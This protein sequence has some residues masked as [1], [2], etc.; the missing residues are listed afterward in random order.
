[1]TDIDGGKTS[2]LFTDLKDLREEISGIR[3]DIRNVTVQ[4]ASPVSQATNTNH[5]GAVGVWAAAWIASVCCAAM[6]SAGI[7]FVM[8]VNGQTARQDAKIAK[9]DDQLSRMQ[10]YLNAIYSIA[11]QLKPKDQ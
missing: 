3:A 10:D 11:P 1:M 4:N 8:S 2:S 7:V 9:Q 5:F 6:L